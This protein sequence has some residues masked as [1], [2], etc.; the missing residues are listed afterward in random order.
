MHVSYVFFATGCKHICC[1]LGCFLRS[2]TCSVLREEFWKP[3]L[4]I[5]YTATPNV[6]LVILE[7]GELGWAFP[8]CSLPSRY[9]R[10]PAS[11]F[12]SQPCGAAL[13]AC[14]CS[15][16]LP[17]WALINPAGVGHFK[18]DR[19]YCIMPSFLCEHVL[20][21]FEMSDRLFHRLSRFWA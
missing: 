10:N 18:M 15:L 17:S 5:C 9:R 12:H 3:K 1:V 8:S 20:S 2:R 6:E 4:E 11:W 13:G 16:S 19:K 21:V 14:F 7:I